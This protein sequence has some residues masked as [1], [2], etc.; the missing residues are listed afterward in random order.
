MCLKHLF[1]RSISNWFP[2]EIWSQ[3]KVYLYLSDYFELRP[4]SEHLLPDYFLLIILT[5]QEINFTFEQQQTPVHTM[6]TNEDA[7][8]SPYR[9]NLL[10]DFITNHSLSWS[11]HFSAFFYSYVYWLI[12]LVFYVIV[13]YHQSILYLLIL[14]ACF[15]L[16]W[17][18]QTFLQRSFARQ[19]SFWRLLILSFFFLFLA[20]LLIQPLSCIFI[21]YTSVQYRCL[22]IN[23]FNVP[24]SI[25]LFRQIYTEDCSE[26]KNFWTTMKGKPID[27][28]FSHSLQDEFT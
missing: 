4:L 9:P 3:L 5:M 10:H 21:Q 7:D 15:I 16:L 8:H 23:L 13:T 14:L 6:G 17:Y 27:E 20:H 24:C 18:G 22:L 19:K 1:D 12:L 26:K 11:H 28:K 2:E 25:K